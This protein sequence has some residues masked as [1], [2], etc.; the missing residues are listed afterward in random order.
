MEFL[1]FLDKVELEI[2]R[3]VEQAGYSTEENTPLCLLSNDFVGFL[4]KRQKKIVIC[5]NNAIK[6]ENYS[7]ISRRNNEIFCTC[8]KYF[9]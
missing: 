3:L 8:Y 7:H 1:I 9:R 2:I 6:R 5:T 4:K